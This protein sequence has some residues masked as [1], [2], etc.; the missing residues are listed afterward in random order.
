MNDYPIVVLAGGLATRLRPITATIPKILIPI[1]GRPFIYHQLELF[2]R[3]GI[4]KVVY[5]LGHMGN[6]VVDALQNFRIGIDIQFSFDG[7]TLLGTGGAI[8]N[9]IPRLGDKFLV[10]YGDSY[11]RTELFPI[12][13][14]FDFLETGGLMCVYKNLNEFDNSNVIYKNETIVDYN[15]CYSPD[16]EYIDYGLMMFLSS[17]F[18]CFKSE[19][20]FDLSDLLRTLVKK[21]QLGGY[22]VFE[23]FYQIG[24]TAGI[25]ELE[26]YFNE[27]KKV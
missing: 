11:L 9:A 17:A 8:R 16:M 18:D 1:A 19:E 27:R 22:E 7:S 3:Q 4:K 10:T 5:C 20:S 24:S 26:N 23:R 13:K 12:I 21:N 15:K 6:M 14:K 25:A 2:E